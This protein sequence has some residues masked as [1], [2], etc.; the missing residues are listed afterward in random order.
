MHDPY[1]LDRF[2]QLGNETKAWMG[3]SW[4]SAPQTID[5][6]PF[7]P[8]SIMTLYQSLA[9]SLDKLDFRVEVNGNVCT[10]YSNIAE[11]IVLRDRDLSYEEGLRSNEVALYVSSNSPENA[12]NDLLPENIAAEYLSDSVTFTYPEGYQIN[13]EE[14]EYQVYFF[15]SG[16]EEYIT[17][18]IGMYDDSFTPVIRFSFAKEGFWLEYTHAGYLL[19]IQMND[20]TAHVWVEYSLPDG[21]LD[22]WD[23]DWDQDYD[24]SAYDEGFYEQT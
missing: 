7:M 24:S 23:Q 4:N 21:Q 2:V 17:I 3:W 19:E 14:L 18:D 8:S 6:F 5:D 15:Y 12:V 11:K 1:C 10:V 22:S 20:K 16:A 13:I 9:E